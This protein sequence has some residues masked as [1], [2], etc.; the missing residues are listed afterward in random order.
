M[1]GYVSEFDDVGEYLPGLAVDGEAEA[2][3]V[4]E[5]LYVVSVWFA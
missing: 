4:D 2:W 3:F 5:C 1:D